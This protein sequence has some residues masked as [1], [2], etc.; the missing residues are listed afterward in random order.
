MALSSGGYGVGGRSWLH[1]EETGNKEKWD[2]VGW[3]EERVFIWDGM[4]GG[5]GGP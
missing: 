4:E 1:E 2:A 3:R 5:A